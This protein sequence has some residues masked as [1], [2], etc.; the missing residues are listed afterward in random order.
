M[1]ALQ[2]SGA[3][4]SFDEQQIFNKLN[5]QLQEGEKVGLIGRNGAGK[6]SLFRVLQGSLQLDEG[7][8]FM[9]K[10]ISMGYLDQLPQAREE[11]LF[12]YCMEA[13]LDLY[14]L[15]RE[16]RECQLALEEDP[17]NE[18]LLEEYGHKLDAFEEQNGY[19]TESRIKGILRGLGFS[20]EEYGRKVRSLS[21]GEERRLYLARLLARDYDV[22]LL[23]EPTNHLDMEAIS[24]LEL[25]LSSLSGAI[26]LVT[27]DREFLDRTVDRI[28]EIEN[29]KGTWYPGNYSVFTEL[30]RQNYLI[31]K[32]TYENYLKK[33]KEEEE[34]LRVFQLR[35]SQNQKFA[36]RARDREKKLERM[37]EVAAPLWLSRSMGLRFKARKATGEDILHCKNLSK[38]YGSRTLFKNL[39]FPLYKGNILGILGGNGTG[40]TTL[41]SILAG[42]LSSDTGRLCYGP[43]VDKGYYRQHQEDMVSSLDLVSYI[44]QRFSVYNHG[45]IRNLLARFLFTGEDVFKSISSLSGGEKARLSLLL[46]MLEERNLLLLDEPTNHLDIYSKETLE[47]ALRHYDGTVILI[48]HDRYFLNR[49]CS[50]LLFLDQDHSEY[51]VGNYKEYEEEKKKR[52]TTKE[53]AKKTAPKKKQLKKKAK[54]RKENIEEQILHL[55]EKLQKIEL[56]FCDMNLYNDSQEVKRLSMER[57]E[58]QEEIDR[59][60]N[61]WGREG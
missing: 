28:Y 44:N 5:F 33:R 57:D 58:I 36:A 29:G 3:V 40:K 26:I 15:E 50:H 41:M 30:K 55:E 17:H 11:T 42:E 23:D 13:F 20:E 1:I 32:R 34:K 51:Y 8:V 53:E 24:W 14:R 21:G 19:A 43:G 4:K 9:G 35:S 7:Q 54:V 48:S 61:L 59:L 52:E 31:E 2:I 39:S 10:N 6:T 27:H 22:L 60:Y 16:I 38:S 45:E 37:E 25:H 56:A 46:L 12:E 49:V 47:E 18:K